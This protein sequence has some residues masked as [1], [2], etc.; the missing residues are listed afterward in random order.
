MNTSLRKSVTVN[1]MIVT[2]KIAFLEELSSSINFPGFI[3]FT[4][5]LQVTIQYTI[6]LI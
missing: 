4:R 5:F 6:L 1:K 3:L 2:H